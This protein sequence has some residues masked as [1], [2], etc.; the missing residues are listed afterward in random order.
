MLE[1]FRI[2]FCPDGGIGIRARLKIVSRKGCGFDSHSGHRG[3]KICVHSS[4][5]ADPAGYSQKVLFTEIVKYASIAQLVEQIPLKDKVV[6]S[7][8]TGRTAL[9]KICTAADFLAVRTTAM[10]CGIIYKNDGL[11]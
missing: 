6:G 4:A 5:V 3:K 1:C 7:I 8:P 9:R 2:N 10:F 11:F